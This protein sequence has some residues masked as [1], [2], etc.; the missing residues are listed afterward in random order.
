MCLCVCACHLDNICPYN[1]NNKKLVQ[2]YRCRVQ[3]E[4]P[5]P[6]IFIIITT[7]TQ[8]T[9]WSNFVKHGTPGQAWEST[10]VDVEL[11]M[12]LDVGA[13]VPGRRWHAKECALLDQIAPFVW[14]PPT[15]SNKP[16]LVKRRD[17]L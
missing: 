4:V 11:F 16:S 1:N 10:G 13:D 2:L 14:N 6:D 17:R 7:R 8:I 5:T 9:Y 12:G 3:S 15:L